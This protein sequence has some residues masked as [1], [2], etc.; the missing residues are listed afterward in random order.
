[1]LKSYHIPTH[2]QLLPFIYFT[3]AEVDE[4]KVADL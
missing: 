1:M 3:M 4:E 2:K